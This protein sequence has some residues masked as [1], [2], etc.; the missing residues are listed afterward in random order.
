MKDLKLLYTLI[1]N[2]SLY[3]NIYKTITTIELLHF[4]L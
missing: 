3:N 2:T 4:C 1:E